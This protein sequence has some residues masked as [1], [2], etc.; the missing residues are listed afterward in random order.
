MFVIFLL[1]LL[2]LSYITYKNQ[3]DYNKNL[4]DLNFILNKSK[5]SNQLDYTKIN[6]EDKINNFISFQKTKKIAVFIKN[7]DIILTKLI[8]SGTNYEIEYIELKKEHIDVKMK[9]TNYDSLI[10]NNLMEKQFLKFETE[11]NDA[12]LFHIKIF[13]ND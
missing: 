6:I 5:A 9:I 12:S 1:N 10:F 7:F 3:K 2:P 13:I 11:K 8:E 4:N